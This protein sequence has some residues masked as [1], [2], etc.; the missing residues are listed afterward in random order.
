MRRSRDLFQSS[1]FFTILF[2]LSIV[3]VLSWKLELYPF[4]DHYLRYMDGDQYFGFYGYLASTFY[5]SSNLLYSWSMS[6]GDGMLSTYAYYAA[7]PF[8]LL[9]VFFKNNLILGMEVIAFLKAFFIS[10]SFCL[11]LNSFDQ[12]HAI[13]KGLF[14]TAYAFIGYVVFYAWNLSWLD[15]VA[16]LPLMLLGLKKLLYEK[17][18]LLYILVIEIGRAH[19]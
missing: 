8:N 18:K 16:L 15:G 5:S 7:S 17:K 6:L 19:V 13:E 14:S 4:G 1:L 9:L 12:E 10:I 3:L 11:L 2:T